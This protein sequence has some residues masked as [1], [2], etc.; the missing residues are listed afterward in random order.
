MQLCS[1][2][3]GAEEL[4]CSSLNQF[5]SC[6]VSDNQMKSA[7]IFWTQ[8]EKSEPKLKGE[9]GLGVQSNRCINIFPDCKQCVSL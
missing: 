6:V 9:A 8:C 5:L 1:D 7:V 3:A 4:H 2:A